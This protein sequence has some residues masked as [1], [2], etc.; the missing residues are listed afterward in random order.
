MDLK[1]QK[2]VA[3]ELL[4]CGESR[5]WIDPNRAEDVA[6][7][8]T[9]SDVRTLIASGTIAAKQKKGVS[10]GRA[11]YRKAQKAKGRRR[12]QG[13]RRGRKHARKPSK[14]TWMQAI[15][16]IR[17][18]LREL[19]HGDLQEVLH[20]GE[21]R[22]VQEQV[23]PGLAPQVRRRDQ[24]VMMMATGPRYKVP[25]RRRREG[26]TDYRRRAAL[27]RSGV[28]RAVVR[29]SNR[30]VTIQFVEY[31]AGADFVVASA[32]SKELVKLGW[33][34]PGKNTPGAYLTGLLA[35]TRAK[36][37]GVDEAVLDIGLREPT[38]GNLMFAALK[39]LL[40]AG[41]D[42]LAGKHLREGT[43]AA[44]EDVKKKIGG[45]E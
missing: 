7:A 19:R 18:R 29:K 43:A 24:G 20:A 11:N 25:F 36:E 42:R 28:P 9:R 10:R 5:V 3:A 6:D 14:E 17:R 41:V 8:I 38:K 4:K 2:R 27:L 44:F 40:D 12:G 13:S 37:K 1:Y 33:T 22:R 16:P 34:L 26:R 39:G 45:G 31:R 35:G 21:G 30:G 15:R 32:V 23:A